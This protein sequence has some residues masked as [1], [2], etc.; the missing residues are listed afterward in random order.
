MDM[1]IRNTR[2]GKQVMWDGYHLSEHR[3][4][5]TGDVGWISPVGTQDGENR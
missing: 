4:G 1:I 3:M 5:K 2:W